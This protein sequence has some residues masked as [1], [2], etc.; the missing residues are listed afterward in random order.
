MLVTG[1]YLLLAGASWGYEIT[2]TSDDPASQLCALPAPPPTSVGWGARGSH[3]LVWLLGLLTRPNKTVN[4]KLPSRLPSGD[5]E[6]CGQQGLALAQPGTAAA[7]PCRARHP[8]AERTHF[9]LHYSSRDTGQRLN[10]WNRQPPSWATDEKPHVGMK[11]QFL[12]I[13]AGLPS[14]CLHC[15]L[16]IVL[17]TLKNYNEVLHAKGYLKIY[18]NYKD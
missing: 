10:V 5:S 8:G 1:Y 17:L 13:Q 2:K 11:E 4:G 9:H 15:S 18:V 3:G 6:S 7:S 12:S 14:Y 16:L